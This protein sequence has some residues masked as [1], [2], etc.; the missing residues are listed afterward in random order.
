[1]LPERA[2][3][4]AFRSEVR[5]RGKTIQRE[6]GSLGALQRIVPLVVNKGEAGATHS[7]WKRQQGNFA[8]II[9]EVASL[10]QTEIVAIRD[11][12]RPR[13]G[14]RLGTGVSK[15][16]PQIDFSLESLRGE[17]CHVQTI[18]VERGVDQFELVVVE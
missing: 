12:I 17:C 13:A 1:M 15:L 6:V 7:G 14:T 4:I 11:R 8:E 3:E 5:G 18:V 2:T 9:R 16:L 10:H